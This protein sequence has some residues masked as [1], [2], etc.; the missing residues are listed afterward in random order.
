MKNIIDVFLT[1]LRVRHTQ[2]YTEKLFKEHPFKSNLY[3]L[4]AMLR[5]YG[6]RTVAVKY[7]DKEN[8]EL[9]FPCILHI[10]GDFVVANDYRDGRV[11]YIW[12]G[13]SNTKSVEEFCK[14]W[15][16]H[17][18]FCDGETSQAREL[19]YKAHL[20]EEIYKKSSKYLIS[21]LPILLCI[22]GLVRNDAL[23]DFHHLLTF[24]LMICGCILCYSLLQKQM[25]GESEFGDKV[26]S[27]FH[28]ADCNNVLESKWAKIGMFSWSEIGMAYFTAMTLSISLFPESNSFVST[29]NW[30]AMFF[31][32][33]SIYIQKVKVQSF[34]V[35]CAFVQGIIWLLGIHDM[36][37]YISGIN[38]FSF[39]FMGF[40]I[41]GSLF[42]FS[43]IIIHSLSNET[44]VSTERG[45]AISNLRAFKSDSDV[46]NS[47]LKRDK[48]ND[49]VTDADSIV[50][51]NINAPIKITVLTNP[52]CNPCGRM[53]DR[54][55]KLMQKSNN[56][57]L[58]Q[59]IF[60]SFNDDV[61]IN[62][63]F[64]IAVYQQRKDFALDVYKRWYVNGHKSIK[65]YPELSDI[66]LYAEGVNNAIEYGK[67]WKEQTGYVA[68]PTVLINGYKL[69]EEY[70]VEDLEFIESL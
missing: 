61:E 36:Y 22:L 56:R 9:V 44:K 16:G 70:D 67:A 25:Y 47:L 54:I 2:Q 14:I 59:Y 20:H 1:Q 41:S 68:T 26:C 5:T 37:I 21:L 40:V 33:W 34:C 69:P 31:G 48:K 35:M 15:T 45:N 8:A 28:H 49:I 51:G 24:L 4:N 55:H 63:R 10:N 23:G 12:H 27:V 58:V 57:F 13:K 66:D 42:L 43:I 39:D 6:L 52:M 64:L 7:Y 65:D 53:H 19:D 18:L 30:C 3:G 62:T 46:M 11:S 38:S 32:V 60:S 29:M 50:F 17:A